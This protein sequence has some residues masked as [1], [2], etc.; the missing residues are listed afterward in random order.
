M[1][2][3]YYDKQKQK[4]NDSGEAK[5]KDGNENEEITIKSILYGLS[6]KK[7]K[8]NIKNNE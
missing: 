6:N 2:R 3:P 7:T 4:T 8:R 5:N 1:I